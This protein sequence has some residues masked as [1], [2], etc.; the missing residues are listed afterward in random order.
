MAHRLTLPVSPAVAKFLAVHLGDDYKLSQTDPFGM[1]LFNMMR[2]PLSDRQYD[3]A[4]GK[5]SARFNV[6]FVP[7]VFY[8]R[9]CHNLSSLTV[10]HFNSFVEN[11]IKTELHAFVDTHVYFKM[12]CHGAIVAFMEKY[13]FTDDDY[14]FDALKKSYQRFKKKHQKHVKASSVLSLH[15]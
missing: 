9:S 2:R 15:N 10:Y 6:R 5:F 3:G 11:I 4:M 13:N 8:D 12:S 7:S 14:S 1:Y